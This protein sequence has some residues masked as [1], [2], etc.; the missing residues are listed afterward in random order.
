MEREKKRDKYLLSS[1][2]NALKVLDFLGVR[3]NIG[4]TEICRGC[5]LDKTS[6]F[7]ILYT[8]ERKDYVYKT[9][10]AKYKLGVK[11]MNYGD[12]VAERQDLIEI[13]TPF[14]QKLRDLCGQSVQLGTLNTIGRV[15]VMHQEKPDN[16]RSAF[17]RIGFELDAYTNSLGK[18]LL[19]FLYPAVQKAVMEQLRFRPHTPKTILSVEV[20]GEELTKITENGYAE[21]CDEHY[22]GFSSVSAPVFNAAK[23]CV[24]GI[25]IIFPSDPDFGNAELIQN[26]VQVA[27]EISRRLGFQD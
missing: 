23:Q 3:D 20:L 8:L 16:P 2:D 19:A 6:V 21:D 22:I 18:V 7:K 26:A 11:F 5:N 4:I 24:A 9:A 13:A 15:I 27:A 17:A 1:V 25:S 12:Q 10:N 14:M